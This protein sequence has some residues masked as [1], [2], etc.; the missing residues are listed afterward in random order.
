[1]KIGIVGL[2]KSGK[3]TLFKLLTGVK[4]QSAS[5]EVKSVP[6]IA[7]I[8]DL[9]FNSL[10]ELY[11]PKKIAPAQIAVELMQDL[12]KRI[13]K[14]SAIFRDIA[15]MD[16][17][18]LVVR[19]FNDEAVYH[20]NGSVDCERDINEINGEFVLHDLLFI[21]KRMERIDL[22]IKKGIGEQQEIEK[23][24]LNRLKK[25]LEQ[26]L[27]LRTCETS[28][29]EMKIIAGYPFITLKEMIIVLN[30]SDEEL[31]NT[32]LKNHLK[33]KYESQ[34]VKIMQISAKLESEINALESNDERLEFMNA[35][36]IADSAI[37]LMSRLCMEALGRISFFTVGKDEV[38]QWLIKKG[39]LAPGAAGVIH[40]DIQ[41]GFIRAEVMKY[42]DLMQNGNEIKV[43]QANKYYV[44]GK[45]YTIEDGDIVSYRFNV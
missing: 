37:N 36:G 38:K 31:D 18:C 27:P 21:E 11:K 1:M 10:V 41:R 32:E 43:K 3:R 15:N 17:L 5:Q 28:E 35:S 6:G 26:D 34:R 25:H 29:D 4:V 19:A 30:I 44:M 40:S 45:D 12:D 39:T 33:N 23:S 22:N 42:D 14:E 2:P 13:I 8:H 24:L 9:R 16:A 20:V 7:D